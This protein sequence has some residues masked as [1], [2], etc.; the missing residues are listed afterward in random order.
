MAIDLIDCR[1]EEE[2]Q[3]GPRWDPRMDWNNLAE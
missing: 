1:K 2:G 3:R